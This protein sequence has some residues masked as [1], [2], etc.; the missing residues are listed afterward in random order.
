[1]SSAHVDR[2]DDK[3]GK[4]EQVGG[5][6]LNEQGGGIELSI[7]VR[8]GAL[9]MSAVVGGLRVLGAGWRGGE[10]S[11][12]AGRSTCGEWSTLLRCWEGWLFIE[13][14]WPVGRVGRSAAG[15][16]WRFGG[17]LRVSFSIAGRRFGGRF[18]LGARWPLS[19]AFAFD[20]FIFPVIEGGRTAP[21]SG[22]EAAAELSASSS[23]SAPGS[24]GSAVWD[25]GGGGA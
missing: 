15:V 5:V 6:D 16:F 11:R 17:S 18:C 23:P 20:D 12:L 9:Q 7:C 4:R 13:P 14:T 22:A 2:A 21:A 10:A 25:G 24:A 8:L 3:P 1:M 19:L